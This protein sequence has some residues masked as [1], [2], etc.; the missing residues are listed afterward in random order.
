MAISVTK[1]GPYFDGG[2][3]PSNTTN[4]KFSQMRD[5]F[6]LNNPTGTISASEL[7]RDTNT[8]NTDPIVPDCTE[9]DD[10][11]TSTDW[12]VSQIKGSIKFYFITQ[13]GGAHEINLDIDAQNWNSNL[14]K[15]I[16]KE[17]RVNGTIA[18]N[19]TSQFAASLNVNAHNL[20]IDLGPSGKILG[21]GGVGGTSGSING[22]PG[23]DALQI[24][25]VGNNVTVDL[26]TGS[27]IYGGGGGGEYGSAGSSGANG[28]SGTCWNWQNSSVGSGCG[29]C[30]DCTNLGSEW[31]QYGGCNG[32]GGCNCGGW[33]W[34][35]GCSSSN[36]SAALCRRKVYTTVAG[37]AGGAGGSGG[38]GGN[39]QGYG[40][41]QTN[42]SAGGAGGS[43]TAW[44]GC[45]GYAGTGSSGTGGANG[46]AG[47]SGGDGGLWGCI[48]GATSN[49]G[50]GGEAG[51][52]ITGSGYTVTGSINS[53][54]IKGSY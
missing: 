14:A 6:R 18:S 47:E 41:P 37:G 34:W 16:V 5:T 46:N 24:T 44:A 2:A 33:W 54:T 19:S 48:G 12:K 52:A 50:N 15:N 13:S 42:G 30:G 36:Y 31:E 26:E 9:N 17:F 21:A 22:K 32:T 1:S 4:I 10:V 38:N 40:Q 45:G 43:G 53:S 11:A 3:S 39:G 51:A 49:S 7:R 20:K 25:N 29:Y 23:G 8:S 28:N 27:Q 35:S